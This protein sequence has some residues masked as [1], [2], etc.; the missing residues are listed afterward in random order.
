MSCVV[1]L[2]LCVRTRLIL[3]CRNALS[4]KGKV[5]DT[6]ESDIDVVVAIHNNMNENTWKEILKWED[7]R[8]YVFLGGLYLR[9]LPGG[10]GG[11]KEEKRG[12]GWRYEKVE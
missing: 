5:G 9:S 8:W 7:I 3:F 2:T 6:E 12:Q 10:K 4:R 11:K 1:G